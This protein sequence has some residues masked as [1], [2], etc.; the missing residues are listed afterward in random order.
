VTN[1]P[2]KNGIITTRENAARGINP[3]VKKTPRRFKRDFSL[4]I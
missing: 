3:K 4:Y 1:R 2:N